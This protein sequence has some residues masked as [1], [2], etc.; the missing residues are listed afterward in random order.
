[1]YAQIANRNLHLKY[2]QPKL[3]YRNLGNGR[4]EDVSAR[5]GAAI[6]A[7]NLGR[8]CAF[9]DFDNDGDVDVVVN[10]LDG[11][12]SVLR[13]DGGNGNNLIIIKCVGTRSNRSGIAPVRLLGD[14]VQ[15]DEVM[16]GS[17]Y[18]SHNDFRLHFGL[19]R[20]AKADFVELAWPSGVKETFRD[21][22]ANHLF[23]CHESKGIVDTGDSDKD[24]D[25]G[26]VET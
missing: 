7:E 24:N 4:F 6:L 20:A 8:G 12:P 21:L 10:N 25:A 9:G 13:N 23:V 14:H 5:A 16:S 22:Q 17:S 11:P 2:R 18:Y 19:G 1:M 26:A 15:I 3:L